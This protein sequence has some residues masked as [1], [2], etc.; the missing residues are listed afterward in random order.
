LNDVGL[1]DASLEKEWET[2]GGVVGEFH[3]FDGKKEPKKGKKGACPSSPF[4]IRMLVTKGGGISRE[5]TNRKGRMYLR[6]GRV[7]NYQYHP[8]W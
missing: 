2:Q 4:L 1:V 8:N 3:G 6:K 5:K 7:D